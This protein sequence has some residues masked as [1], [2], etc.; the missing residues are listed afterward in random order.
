MPKRGSPK[1]STIVARCSLTIFAMLTIAWTI[2]TGR[3]HA[4]DTNDKVIRSKSLVGIQLTY[5][6]RYKSEGYTELRTVIGAGP[7]SEAPPRHDLFGSLEATEILTFLEHDRGGV[8]ASIRFEKPVIKIQVDSK[9]RPEREREIVK[10]LGHSAS[11]YFDAQSRVTRLEFPKEYPLMASNFVKAI[12][13]LQQFAVPAG[14]NPTTWDLVE[15]GANGRYAAHYQVAGISGQMTRVT[16]TLARSLNASTTERPDST[17][18]AQV[19]PQGTIQISV[20]KDQGTVQDL[21]GVSHEDVLIQG[22]VLASENTTVS[23][24]IVSSVRLSQEDFNAA[25][26]ALP[27]SNGATNAL[28]RPEKGLTPNRE[29][30][31]QQQVLGTDSA[32]SLLDALSEIDSGSV[33]RDGQMNVYLKLKAL[34]YLHPEASRTLGNRLAVADSKNPSTEMITT[35]L[36]AVASPE[37]QDALCAAIRS[38]RDD[39]QT[40][41]RLV[42]ALGSLP[43]PTERVVT[44]LQQLSHS[45][46][47]DV[48]SMAL[49]ALGGAA[50]H[51]AQVSNKRSSAIV[52]D[53]AS[54][55]TGSHAADEKATLLLAL[56]NSGTVQA[57]NV[58]LSQRNDESTEMRRIAINA[59]GDFQ[60]DATLH[61]LC[62][63]LKADS[64]PQVRS[65]A[66]QSLAPRSSAKLAKDA[67]LQAAQQDVAESVR[68]ASIFALTALIPRDVHVREVVN[69]IAQ[70]DSSEGVRKQ[71]ASLLQKNQ[72]P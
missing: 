17:T 23:V 1:I 50:K 41:T 5:S 21:E 34:V 12:V 44:L 19:V 16:K 49:L 63:A 69:A 37:A 11:V 53:L 9:S 38:K 42:P 25:L 45:S 30:A 8:R 57:E 72:S 51:L 13:T 60:S 32:Q 14:Q 58:I 62:D 26:R 54:Q 15:I 28:N 59:L 67:L 22:H 36:S 18:T 35:A 71:A 7:G 64:E 61:A 66:A 4:G 65:A 2:P 31:M 56:G 47:R 29:R 46:S 48:Q 10:N 70:N 27:R 68:L 55:L 39:V 40:L 33:S 24:H 43:Q 20:N 3:T 6:V 52:S